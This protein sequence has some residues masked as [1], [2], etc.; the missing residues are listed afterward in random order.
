MG[1]YE[2]AVSLVTL[3]LVTLRGPP[4]AELWIDRKIKPSS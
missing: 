4:A 3:N 2:V 1:Q